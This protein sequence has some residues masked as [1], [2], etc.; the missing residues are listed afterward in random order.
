MLTLL[1]YANVGLLVSLIGVMATLAFSYSAAIESSVPLGLQLA[2]HIGTILFA[3][4]LKL[5][6]I[7]RLTALKK[8]GLPM[9]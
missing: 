2:A 5:S 1:R 6:Y 3:T 4:L 9:H 7:A 8:L